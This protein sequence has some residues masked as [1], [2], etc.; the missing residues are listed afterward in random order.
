MATVTAVVQPDAAR[1]RVR[2]SDVGAVRQ[3]A[4]TVDGL[5][6]IMFKGEDQEGRRCVVFGKFVTR[7]EIILDP[8]ET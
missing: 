6:S 1:I 4:Q 3:A 2:P 5:S 8:G 7:L